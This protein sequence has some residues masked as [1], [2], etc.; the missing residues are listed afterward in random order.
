MQPNTDYHFNLFQPFTEHGRKI[1]NLILTMLTIWA[2]CIFG[3]QILLKLV[4][5]PTPEKT[6][7]RFEAA[8]APMLTGSTDPMVI[9]EFL[10]SLVLTSGKS[11]VKPADQEVLRAG[12]NL[13]LRML[14]PETELGALKTNLPELARLKEKIAAANDQNYL[15]LK[16]GISKIQSELMTITA[17][18]T[19]FA[20]GGLESVILVSSLQSNVPAG[21]SAPG[22]SALP[23]IMKLYL[24]HNQSF[25]TDFKFLGF[26]FHYF[27]TA[28]FLLILFVGMCL[29]YNLRLDRRMKIESIEE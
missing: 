22:L 15:D 26:P 7:V 25:L 12:I 14:V 23:E 17:P 2:I 10:H 11:V 8:Y 29:L 28:V 21:L 20:P 27:Y 9:K 18:Y 1:R 6:L 4:E 16:T 5:K 3:F 19:G 13:A 24:T